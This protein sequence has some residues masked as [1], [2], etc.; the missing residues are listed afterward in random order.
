MNDQTS[1]GSA[2]LSSQLQPADREV[3]QRASHELVQFVTTPAQIELPL[4]F[5]R[6]V[7]RSTTLGHIAMALDAGASVRLTSFAQQA[8][9]SL[10]VVA[11]TAWTLV[12]GRLG[13]NQQGVLGGA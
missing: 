5:G 9:Y 11:A 13:S 6:P 3:G 10:P 8:G 7:L 2:P 1:D 12:L 4:T